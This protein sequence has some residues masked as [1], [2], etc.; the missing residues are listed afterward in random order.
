MLL[1]RENAGSSIKVVIGE[2]NTHYVLAELG[3]AVVP[4]LSYSLVCFGLKAH[5]TTVGTIELN[6]NNP[7][8]P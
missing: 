5:W 1:V 4:T 8:K 7:D 3:H 2:T 6:N